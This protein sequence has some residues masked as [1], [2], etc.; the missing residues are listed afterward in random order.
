MS[1]REKKSSCRRPTRSPGAT[2]PWRVSAG[3]ASRSRGCSQPPET[4][5]SGG[6]NAAVR[7]EKRIRT[8]LRRLPRR[9][10]ERGSRAVAGRGDDLSRT[11][12]KTRGR[13]FDICSTIWRR[14]RWGGSSATRSRSFP[15]L[16]RRSSGPTPAA[17]SRN[18]DST[19]RSMIC[20]SVA[21]LGASRSSRS[22]TA[23][24]RANSAITFAASQR[25]ASS[26]S[27]R[28]TA[29]R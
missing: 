10:R 5:A 2:S 29:R 1:F 3:V 8:R 14:S 21:P 19:A 24:P 6:R 9:G 17:G 28:P 7:S 22:T 16:S 4:R 15:P 11:P 13:V 25:P 20:G 12:R 18:S 27:L 23:T 26:P